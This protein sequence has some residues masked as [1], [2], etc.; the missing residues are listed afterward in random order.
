M[1][2]D[3]VAAGQRPADATTGHGRQGPAGG[4]GLEAVV[5]LAQAAEVAGAGWPAP[6]VGHL[7]VEVASSGP[8]AAAGEAAAPVT[9]TDEAVDRGVGPIGGRPPRPADRVAPADRS[10]VGEREQRAGQGMGDGDLRPA[11]QGGAGE[12]PGKQ[13]VGKRSASLLDG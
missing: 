3:L 7:V 11:G 9:G 10:G 4:E 13:Q 1:G 12:P 6:V 8:G 2:G 5:V